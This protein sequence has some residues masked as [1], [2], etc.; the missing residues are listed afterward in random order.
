M[1]CIKQ[2]KCIY[3]D[4]DAALQFNRTYSKHLESLGWTK[5]SQIH[6]YSF[7]K[8]KQK[9]LPINIMPCRQYTNCRT[10]N[11]YQ[12]IYQR[13][14]GTI[15]CEGAWRNEKAFRDHLQ[16]DRGLKGRKVTATLNNLIEEIIEM[17]EK[18]T[19][20]KS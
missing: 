6:V 4:V 19:N 5:A 20:Q 1:K 10:S 14:K 12:R 7:G 2:I 8:T 13:I 18:F 3:G 15:C 17:T 9:D 16:L 11:R